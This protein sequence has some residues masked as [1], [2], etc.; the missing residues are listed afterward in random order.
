MR[1]RPNGF[2]LIE[3]LVVLVIVCVLYWLMLGPSSALMVGKR[4]AEC[5]RR[6]QQVAISMQLYAAEH[7]GL[8]PWAGGARTSEEAFNLLV[9]A[10]ASDVSLFV[11][12]LSGKRSPRSGVPLTQAKS[13]F[14]YYMGVRNPASDRQPLVSDEQC[15]TYP[16][17]TGSQV[18]AATDRDR[19]ANHG[20]SGGN[21]VFADGH[22]Q[23]SGPLTLIPLPIPKGGALLNPKP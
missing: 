7:D 19:G 18:F 4:K 12:P 10:Y 8:Y 14:A 9:P 1:R 13:S 6:L 21:I 2:S 22:L 20:K 11:C 3:L 5:A 17:D 15:N 16:K 23:E